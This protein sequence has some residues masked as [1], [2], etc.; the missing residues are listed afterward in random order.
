MARKK[1]K[2]RANKI[3]LKLLIAFGI[4]LFLLG[5]ITQTQ[6]YYNTKIALSERPK[7]SDEKIPV[8]TSLSIPKQKLNIKVEQGGIVSGKWVLSKTNAL[9][10]PTSGGLGEGFNTIIYAHNTRDLFGK[11]KKSAKG[12]LIVLSDKAGKEYRYK[13]YSIEDVDPS[14][15]RKLYSTQKD[16]VTLFTCDGW[17]DKSR[18]VVRAQKIPLH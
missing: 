7:Y 12:D 2:K 16:I 1:Q 18:L 5:S 15:L 6:I 4:L 14:D 17:A 3:Y 13:I 8:P 11:L 10:L 9:Y